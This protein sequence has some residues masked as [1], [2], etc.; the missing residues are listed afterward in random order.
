MQSEFSGSYTI[1]LARPDD[2]PRLAQIEQSAS[3][4]FE[5]T[6][7]ECEVVGDSLPPA[8]LGARQKEGRVWVAVDSNGEP[9]GFTVVKTV[10]GLAHLHELSVDPAHGRKG[11]GSGL[12]RAVVE[13]ASQNGHRSLTLS[14]F[15][16]IEWNAPYYRRLGF[17]DLD[18]R[19][20]SA[21]LKEIRRLEAESGL[22]IEDR[23]CMI[24]K[25]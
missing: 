8:F 3:M 13:W 22:P 23:V 7:Y 17:R 24:L 5:G 20:L 16:D 10:D 18:D 1:R 19:E 6:K 14:T 11:I 12:I 25:L 4:L 15:K 21:G 9:V 2:L